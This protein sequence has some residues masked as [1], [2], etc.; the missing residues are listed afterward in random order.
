MS[1]LASGLGSSSPRLFGAL[2]LRQLEWAAI[3][4]PL[5][6]LGGYY[7]LMIGPL[8]PFFH[9]WGGFALLLGLLA[10][11]V[12]VFSR[13]V[14]GA[15]RRMQREI[16]ELHEQTQALVVGQERQHIAREMHDGMAQLV[17]FVNT[18]AQAVEQFLRGGDEDAARAH[19]AELSEAARKVYADIREGIVALQIDVGEDRSLH[20]ILDEYVEEFEHFAG[21][22][23]E[24]VWEA[25]DDEL[26]L[27][28]SVE[29]QVLRIVQEALTNVRRHA[30]AQSATVTFAATDGVLTV[31]V[32]D[33]GQ[34]FDPEQVAPRGGWPQFGLRAMRERAQAAGGELA[35][36]SAP[37]RGT[38]VRASFAGVAASERTPA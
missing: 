24:V 22:P 27:S 15:V 16:A 6:F 31:T 4:L 5:A 8:H 23:V 36:E 2:S 11:A 29:L 19:L 18:K 3:V 9:S 17:S 28:P 1:R 37:G 10:V 14:F 26:Q 20:Q 38:I 35:V 34:G 25:G 13:S 7:Y 12:W 33:D 30:H 32:E 21:L